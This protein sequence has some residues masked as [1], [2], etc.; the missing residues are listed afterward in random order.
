M[1]RDAQKSPDGKAPPVGSAEGE[2]TFTI[3]DLARE[4]G[5]TLRTLRFYE[6]R[7]L[8]TPR[9]S[10]MTRLYSEKA[11]SRLALILKG[12]HLGFTLTEIRAMLEAHLAGELELLAQTRDRFRSPRS[13]LSPDQAA[14][15]AFRCHLF[16]YLHGLKGSSYVRGR[17]NQ[18]RTTDDIRA[19]LDGCFERE[20]NFRARA[21]GVESD[22]R[23]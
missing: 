22:A 5:V 11:R 17:L 12:K 1:L 18:M 8:I 4:F 14:A 7:G 23:S 2:N 20:A 6:D 21:P 10:G 15:L 13:V 19:A 16:R 3:G 9:R